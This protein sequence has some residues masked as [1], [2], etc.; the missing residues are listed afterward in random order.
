MI[1]T[2][3]T[4]S[5]GMMTSSPMYFCTL[6]VPRMPRCWMAK[7]ISIRTTP[8]KKMA[9]SE[10]LTG[11]SVPWNSDQLRMAGVAA[12][13]STVMASAAV[14]PTLAGSASQVATCGEV[15]VKAGIGARAFK[16]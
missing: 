6:A 12:P 15:S 4:I 13:V 1:G 8:M 16:M 7:V 2:T 3:P 11:P 9:F 10:K 5:I 14:L